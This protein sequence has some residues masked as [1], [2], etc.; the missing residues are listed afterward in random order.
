MC[1]LCLADFF[2][3]EMPKTKIKK[4]KERA[5]EIKHLLKIAEDTSDTVCDEG[6]K[7]VEILKEEQYKLSREM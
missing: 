6:N 4:V 3:L 1:H 2:Q 7:V 5:L